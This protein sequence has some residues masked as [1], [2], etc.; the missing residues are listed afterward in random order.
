[1]VLTWWHA[2]LKSAEFDPKTQELVLGVEYTAELARVVRDQ[3]GKVISGQK[4]KMETEVDEWQFERQMGSP[5]PNWTLVA[6]G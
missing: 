2:R 4:N 5:D 1:M 3:D 6:T